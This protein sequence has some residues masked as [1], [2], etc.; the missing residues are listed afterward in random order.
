MS[1]LPNCV[2]VCH[3]RTC[4]KQGAD[5]VLAALKATPLDHV[6]IESCG[7]LGQCGNGPMILVLPGMFWYSHVQPQEVT[8]LIEQHLIGG[9]P[10]KKML[11]LRFHSQDK[12]N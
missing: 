7:C 10:V 1:N 9:E 4:K 6:S 2:K 12:S 11:Y 3:N 5:Q 8:K